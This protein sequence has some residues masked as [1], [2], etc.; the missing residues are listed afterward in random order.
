MISLRHKLYSGFGGLLLVMLVVSGLSVM[1]FTRFSHALEKVFRENYDSVVYCREMKER[2]DL[3]DARAQRL[4]WEPGGNPQINFEQQQSEFEENLLRQFK[5]IS[6]PGERERTQQL[7]DKWHQFVP[8]YLKLDS[9]GVD[10][11]R[12]YRDDLLPRLADMKQSAQQIADMNMNNMVS[13]N[14]RVKQTLTAVRNALGVLVTTG[15]LLSALVVWTAGASMLHPLSALTKSARQ[16]EAGDLDQQLVVK[17]RDEVGQLAEAF[18]SMTQRLR[19]FRRLD[20]QR[21]LRTQQTTQLAIDSLPDAVFVIGPDQTVEIAN[22][23]ARQHFQIEPGKSLR[24]LSLRWLPPLYESVQLHHKP[25]EPQGYASALQLF[26]QGEERFLLPR[27][28]PMLSA[29]QELIGVT[30]ILADVTP[31]RRADEAKSSM[32]LTVS[33]ELRTP[34]TG[35]RMALSLLAGNGFGPVTDKQKSLIGTAREDSD[36]LYRIIDNLLNISR[37][38]SGRAQLVFRPMSVG[39]IVVMALDPLR[40]GFAGKNISLSTEIAADLPNVQA[41]ALSISSALTNLLSNAMKFTPA[42]G[43]VKLSAVTDAG[44]VRISVADSGPGIPEPYRKRIFEKFFRV[45]NKDGPTGAGLGLTIAHEIVEAH[46]G[47]LTFDSPPEGGTTFNL[48]LPYRT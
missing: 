12:L 4:I 44:K 28:M 5:N 19:E 2:L 36:R 34:L 23:A 25:I 40:P 1:V 14:G 6:L 47:D 30:V 35:L 31:L 8:H 7:S 41:D 29:D 13:V 43:S 48:S 37:L 38:E 20:H 9:P 27:A 26:D 21:L 33:H 32:V 17:S 16:I 18:N 45:P 46:G 11:V 3:L 24:D 10:R 42:G 22:R 39:E 15:I